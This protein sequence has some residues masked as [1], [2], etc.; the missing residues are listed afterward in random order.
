M[1]RNVPL[2]QL[3]PR[4]IVESRDQADAPLYVICKAGGRGQQACNRFQA[5][6]FPMW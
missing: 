1:R 5:I 4:T 2:D 3:D 6:G